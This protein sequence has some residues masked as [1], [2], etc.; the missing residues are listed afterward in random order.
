M[1]SQM[2]AMTLAL[3]ALIPVVS[4]RYTKGTGLA[5]RNRKKRIRRYFIASVSS[6][7]LFGI[8]VTCSLV[9]LVGECFR[10][11]LTSFAAAF[12]LAGVL[13]MSVAVFGTAREFLGLIGNATSDEDR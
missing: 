10:H 1:A 6:S 5:E 8:A 4:P 13:T 7:A 9:A 12:T 2:F 3:V 11:E